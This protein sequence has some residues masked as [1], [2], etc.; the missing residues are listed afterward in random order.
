[1]VFA[2]IFDHKKTGTEILKKERERRGKRGRERNGGRWME[3][4]ARGR[5]SE[6]TT[7]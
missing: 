6:N 4:E 7:Q 5:E 1:M 2:I 3:G